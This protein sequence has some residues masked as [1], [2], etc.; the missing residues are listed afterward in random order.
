MSASS[1]PRFP[2]PP[3]TFVGRSA[4]LSALRA[5]MLEGGARLVT[6]LGPPGMGK[7][8]LALR[9]AEEFSAQGALANCWFVD[10]TAARSLEELCATVS[11]QLGVGFAETGDMDVRIAHALAARGEILSVLDNSAQLV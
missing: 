3:T 11:S 1:P 7:T 2:S 6:I 10:L 9:Y 5:L 4:E 8:R